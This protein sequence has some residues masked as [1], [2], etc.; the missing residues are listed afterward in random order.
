[1]IEYAANLGATTYFGDLSDVDLLKNLKLDQAAMI[2]STVPEKHANLGLLY[3]IKEA[4][5]EAPVVV[6]AFDDEQAHELYQAGADFVSH[7]YLFAS[8]KLRH[9][10]EKE[11]IASY[12]TRIAHHDKKRIEHRLNFIR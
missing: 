5:I 12:I 11:D 7:P 4:K 9:I 10:A 1:M 3:H 8:R 6:P 2:I